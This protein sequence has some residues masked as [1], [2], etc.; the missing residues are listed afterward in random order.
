MSDFFLKT[1]KVLIRKKSLIFCVLFVLLLLI[2]ILNI[3]YPSLRSIGVIY[4]SDAIYSC[5]IIL[6]LMS[7][8]LISPKFNLKTWTVFFLLVVLIYLY[9]YFHNMS[10]TELNSNLNLSSNFMY[11]EKL[12][13]KYIISLI[14]IYSL[15][16]VFVKANLSLKELYLIVL[17]SSL[18]I[19]L[20]IISSNIFLFGKSTYGFESIFD[21]IFSW[22]NSNLSM[23]DP[24]LLTTRFYF[25][26]GNSLS[27]IMFSLFPIVIQQTIDCIGW[28]KVITYIIVLMHG[29]AMYM[30]GTRVSTYGVLI[31]LF[32]VLVINIINHVVSEKDFILDGLV[33]TIFLL[34]FIY[35]FPYT[36]TVK[37]QEFNRINNQLILDDE[38]IRQEFLNERDDSNIIKGT[39]EY[40]YYYMYIFEQY[41]WLLSIPENYYLISYPY[42]VDPEFYVDLI[43]EY[44]FNQRKNSRQFQKIFYDYK[45]NELSFNQKLFGFSY[46]RVYSGSL[47]L[48]QDFVFHKYTLGYIGY[49]LFDVPWLI[50]LIYIILKLRVHLLKFNVNLI[51]ML[52]SVM[53]VYLS[54]FF[55]GH[56]FDRYLPMFYLAM[57]LSFI[58][59]AYLSRF[60]SNKM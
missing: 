60:N 36:P 52:L 50:G 19:S 28:K 17:T 30:I 44:D 5:I 51:I 46:S 31:M 33:L 24:K 58:K 11:S 41:Y 15:I 45:W 9:L 25:S 22:F 32:A 43:F 38:I 3:L 13:I 6:L 48:E 56:V 23:V 49:I 35:I 27:V 1:K 37:N 39:E 4:N 29:I 12:E 59:S 8:L 40:Y 53:S 10:V 21:N 2:D 34:L 55:T 16:F 47:I 57:L 20:M 14:F 18:I 54:S 26:E 42:T 7:C